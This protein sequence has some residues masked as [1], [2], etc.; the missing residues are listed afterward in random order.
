MGCRAQKF[1]NI[2]VSGQLNQAKKI[3]KKNNMATTNSDNFVGSTHQNHSGINPTYLIR[4]T[5]MTDLHLFWQDL[6]GKGRA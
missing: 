3:I 5:E 4:F 2:R 6:E 1:V